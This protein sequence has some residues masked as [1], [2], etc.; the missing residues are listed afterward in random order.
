MHR[1]IVRKL[2]FIAFKSSL[3]IAKYGGLI[4]RWIHFVCEFA[5]WHPFTKP[6]RFKGGFLTAHCHSLAIS[7]GVLPAS[8][9]SV[10]FRYQSA[11]STVSAN[12]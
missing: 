9:Y 10:G 6:N 7:S 8:K 11:L 5:S 4:Y 2:G 3:R 1:N 12:P